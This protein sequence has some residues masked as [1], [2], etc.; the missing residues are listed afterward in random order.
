MKKNNWIVRWL[1]DN[2]PHLQLRNEFYNKYVTDYEADRAEIEE[3]TGMVVE[4][5]LTKTM[6]IK[7]LRSWY[8]YENVEV[9]KL[10]SSKQ[11]KVFISLT[12]LW[13]AGENMVEDKFVPL[14]RYKVTATGSIVDVKVY[15]T[16]EE[17]M[18]DYPE[19]WKYGNIKKA[20]LGYK[21]TDKKYELKSAYNYKWKIL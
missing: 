11:R 21:R 14:K 16:K 17:L 9:K 2:S 15:N 5:V 12:K 3:E 6:F 8:G 10:I 20:A 18:K 1:K 4:P 7:A 13:E 19:H